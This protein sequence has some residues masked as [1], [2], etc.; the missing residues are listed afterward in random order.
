[1][2][3]LLTSS[4]PHPPYLFLSL[5]SPST[6][7]LLIHVS[8]SLL[9]CIFPFHHP[10][11]FH[12][13]QS[14]FFFF[15]YLSNIAPHSSCFGLFNLIA[16]IIVVFCFYFI[17]ITYVLKRHS[18]GKTYLWSWKEI[19]SLQLEMTV[20]FGFSFTSFSLQVGLFFWLYRPILLMSKVMCRRNFMEIWSATAFDLFTSHSYCCMSPGNDSF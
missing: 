5:Q 3:C 19:I 11:Q 7:S 15:F 9:L 8:L 13:D 10:F 16:L 6:S 17:S 1:M 20:T 4:L 12:I 14:L 18:L 2:W